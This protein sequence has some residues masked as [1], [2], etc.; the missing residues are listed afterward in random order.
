TETGTEVCIAANCEPRHVGQRCIGR[1]TGKIEYRLVDEEG[2]DVPPG[3]PGEL[4]V[5]VAGENPR[6][7]FF[8]GYYK[9]PEAT[10]KAWE[11]GYFHTGD[12]VRV[13]PDG[14]FFFVDRRKNI[15]RRS[16]ENIAAVEVEGVLFQHPAVSN[17]AVAPV[18]DELRGEE[19]AACIIA[20]PG[21]TPG[22]AL[23]EEIFGFCNERLAYYKVPAYYLFMDALPMT[24]SQK[25]QRGEVKRIAADRVG[26]GDCIDLRDRK[27]R[28]AKGH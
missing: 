12:V 2:N 7:G 8:S 22:P 11:G 5:R 9:D 4:L 18:P 26:R 3:E 10:E 14:S 17:C 27:R 24:P 15:I 16:G 1:P 23:A 28:P 21:S 20:A 13:G 6:R 25:I 19:V